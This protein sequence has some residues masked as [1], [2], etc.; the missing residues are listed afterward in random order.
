MW[1]ADSISIF[2]NLEEFFFWVQYPITCVTLC[3]LLKAIFSK[4]TYCY[5]NMHLNKMLIMMYGAFPS[6][7][8]ARFIS[9]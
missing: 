6:S 9:I 2:D 7:V 5:S 4:T 3:F 8:R 1:D